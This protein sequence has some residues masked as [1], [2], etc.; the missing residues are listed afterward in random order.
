MT[1]LSSKSMSELL[2]M[3]NAKAELMDRPPVKR[4]ADRK[5]AEKRVA[6]IIAAIGGVAKAGK[7]EPT[8]PTEL[9][10]VT[11]KAAKATKTA[12]KRIKE[13]GALVSKGS[14][15]DK[16]FN[17][18]SAESRL[19]NQQPISKL[20]VAVYG[21]SRK[22]YKGPLMM[23]MK[24]LKVVLAANKTGLEIRKTRENKENHFGLHKKN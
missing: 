8:V 20:L 9:P 24:G 3:Y 16:L 22:D 18:M 14:F 2:T 12:V 15:R 1:D 17:F 21:E 6:Q 11:A 4:F 19:N 5:S 7:S 10:P 23:V 13:D